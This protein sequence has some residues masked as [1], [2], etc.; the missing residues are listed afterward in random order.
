MTGG[1]G[2]LGEEVI[3]L[4]SGFRWYGSIEIIVPFEV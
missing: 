1:A 4:A 3:L 2:L